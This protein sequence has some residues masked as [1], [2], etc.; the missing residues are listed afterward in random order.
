MRRIR[1]KLKLSQRAASARLG[2]GPSSFHKYEAGN[3]L[4]SQALSNLLRLL[5]RDPGLLAI[6]V[7]ATA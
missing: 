5:D 6:L 7:E 1:R 3:I 2:G 4:V